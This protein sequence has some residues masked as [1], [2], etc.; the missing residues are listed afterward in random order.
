MSGRVYWRCMACWYV[1]QSRD[2]REVTGCKPSKPWENLEL[3]HI[4]FELM[5]ISCMFRNLF[6]IVKLFVTP[7]FCMQ[8][9]RRSWPTILELGID[10]SEPNRPGRH[11]GAACCKVDTGAMKEQYPWQSPGW[12]AGQVLKG[13]AF[14]PRRREVVWGRGAEAGGLLRVRV[15][16]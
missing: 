11:P 13:R 14:E 15:E 7:T 4:W 5:F 9:H 16:W 10:D 12:G 3:L 1:S 6:G 8:P 2:S